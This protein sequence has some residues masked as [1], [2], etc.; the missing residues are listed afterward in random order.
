MKRSSKQL[1][2]VIGLLVS[3]YL[4]SGIFVVR[5]DE[6]A[7]VR[8][9]GRLVTT[10][11]GAPKV[12]SSG[13]HWD[14]PWPFAVSDRVKLREVRTV[15]VCGTSRGQAADPAELLR[16]VAENT[17]PQFLTGDKNILNMNVS[18]QYQISERRLADYLYGQRDL[19][20]RMTLIVESI[21]TDLVSRS[22]VDYVH[23]LGL[24]EL[25]NRLALESERVV[26]EQ[27][28]GI[29]LESVTINE[30]SPPARVKADFLDVSDARNDR[31][32]YIEAA[33]A[34]AQQRRSEARAEQRRI[35]DQ[36]AGQA[37][38]VVEKAR[39]EADSFTSLLEDTAGDG[40]VR[41]AASRRLIL[42][43]LYLDTA[44][45]VLSVVSGK[46]M[47]DGGREVDLTILRSE[48]GE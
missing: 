37:H 24:A 31:Q 25:Q 4:A 1:L 14:L 8:R 5:V 44:E 28:L 13:L 46:V 17:E 16:T 29:R 48:S 22:G 34:F 41:Q 3:A 45:A 42:Q 10:P 15:Q 2:A 21:L 35:V 33:Q 7:V 40:A 18:I 43:R 32:K 6:I 23:P 9:F 30:V 38:H 26:E 39:G 27:G 36:A 20:R 11:D 47:L 19:E 12:V